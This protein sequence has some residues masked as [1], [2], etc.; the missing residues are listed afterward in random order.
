MPPK[1]PKTRYF[2]GK[3][4]TALS[5]S[6]SDSEAEEDVDIKPTYKQ[7]QKQRLE[8]ERNLVAGGAGRVI[9]DVKEIVREGAKAKMGGGMKMDLGN[10]QVGR[11]VGD[12]G[13]KGMFSGETWLFP[14]PRRTR[15]DGIIPIFLEE[16][17]EE[18]ESEEEEEPAAPTAKADEEESS[19]YETD[20]EEESEEEVKKPIFRPVF[21]PK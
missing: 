8:E 12:G 14:P 2:K 3:A 20:T 18:E 19:E 17:S 16:S 4:P 1:Q 15:A 9:T 11:K 21:V 6:E 13:V 10:V 7:R 5:E